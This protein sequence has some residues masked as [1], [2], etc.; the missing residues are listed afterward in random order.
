MQSMVIWEGEKATLPHNFA[1]YLI[2]FAHLKY[3]TWSPLGISLD[4]VGAVYSNLLESLA[5]LDQLL[6]QQSKSLN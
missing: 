2:T 6:F 3:T 5:L 1:T 4:W